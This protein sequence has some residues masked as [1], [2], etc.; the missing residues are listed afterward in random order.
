[1]TKY[2]LNNVYT[3]RAM[4]TEAIYWYISGLY[5]RTHFSE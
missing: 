5:C 4:N 3:E 1:M 2:V